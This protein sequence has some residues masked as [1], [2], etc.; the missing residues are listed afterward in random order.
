MYEIA[1]RYREQINPMSRPFSKEDTEAIK[2]EIGRR[3]RN[4]LQIRVS[5][6]YKGIYFEL[7]GPVTENL[8]KELL[9]RAP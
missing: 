7:I 6:G 3:V 5:K 2:E 9:I 1:K 4:E 8:L